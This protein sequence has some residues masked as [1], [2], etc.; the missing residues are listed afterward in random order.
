MKLRDAIKRAEKLES[1]LKA[2]DAVAVHVLVELCKRL[3]RFRQPLRDL[4]AA[5]VP[6]EADMNQTSLFDKKED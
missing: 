1:E 2:E 5:F 4:T 6:T 3:E